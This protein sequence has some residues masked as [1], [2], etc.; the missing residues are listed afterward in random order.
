MGRGWRCCVVVF[1]GLSSE[2]V[3]VVAAGDV[4]AV[5]GSL[6]GDDGAVEEGEDEGD[7][8]SSLDIS[9]EDSDG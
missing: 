7:D 4:G 3:G 8:C 1:W 5:E 9:G 6:E 2:E